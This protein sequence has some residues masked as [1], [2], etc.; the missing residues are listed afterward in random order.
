MMMILPDIIE[1]DPFG[2]KRAPRTLRKRALE[3][4]ERFC[5]LLDRIFT[6]LL[7]FRWRV[8]RRPVVRQIWRRGV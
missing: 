7:S 1:V 8:I 6:D 3:R 2:R 4:H 5:Y